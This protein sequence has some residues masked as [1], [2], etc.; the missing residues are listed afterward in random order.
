MNLSCVG[1]VHVL[2]KVGEGEHGLGRVEQVVH[3]DEPGIQHRLNSNQALY[4]QQTNYLLI[5]TT[6]PNHRNVMD[7]P[8][9]ITSYSVRS[10]LKS[11]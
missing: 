11:R 9:V 2:V 5:V 8:N 1:G 10:E 7:V 6:K 3:R 4:T